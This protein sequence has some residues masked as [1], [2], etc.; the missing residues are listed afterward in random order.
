MRVLELLGK[1][2]LKNEEKISYRNMEKELG[3]SRETL[4]KSIK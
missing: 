3:I 2:N 4:R 1:L